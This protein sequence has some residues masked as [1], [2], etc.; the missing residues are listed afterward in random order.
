MSSK[1]SLGILEELLCP[2]EILKNFMNKSNWK[3]NK[4]NDDF[5]HYENF[6]FRLSI[7]FSNWAKF[8]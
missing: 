8:L 1:L 6:E 7:L 5:A 3:F 4:H 2:Q